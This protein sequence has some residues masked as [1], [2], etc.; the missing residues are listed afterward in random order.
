MIALLQPIWPVNCGEAKK[1]P[2]SALR[3]GA[4]SGSPGLAGPG[5]CAGSARSEQ[6][7]ERV[8]MSGEKKR[9]RSFWLFQNPSFGGQR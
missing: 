8:L 4:T 2:V 3:G 6:T 5:A 1:R 7:T 9:A